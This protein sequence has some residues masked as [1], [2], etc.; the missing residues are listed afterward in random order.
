LVDVG[1]YTIR[2]I[3]LPQDDA[4]GPAKLSIDRLGYANI[5]KHNPALVSRMT[6]LTDANGVPLTTSPVIAMTVHI[7][8]SFL[9]PFLYPNEACHYDVNRNW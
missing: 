2:H 7:L 9:P 1:D 6:S 8:F 3:P 4:A 5:Q